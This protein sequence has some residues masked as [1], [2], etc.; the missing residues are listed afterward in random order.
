MSHRLFL[1]ARAGALKLFSQE[2]ANVALRQPV[3]VELLR[4]SSSDARRATAPIFTAV[5]ARLNSCPNVTAGTDKSVRATY[6]PAISSDAGGGAVWLGS[7]GQMMRPCSSN[8]MP[9][10]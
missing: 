9:R 1:F 6:S 5:L 10:L 2:P 4:A 7:G 3:R 8:F